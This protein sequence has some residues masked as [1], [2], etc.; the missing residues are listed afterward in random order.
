[1]QGQGYSP[2]AEPKEQEDKPELQELHFYIGI[3]PL[4]PPVTSHSEQL[5]HLLFYGS[6]EL[7][8]R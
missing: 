7:A 6:S 8:Q 2:I 1:M 4:Q 5:Y 3:F